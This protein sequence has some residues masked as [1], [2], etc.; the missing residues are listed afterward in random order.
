M[1]GDEWL[2]T[3]GAAIGNKSTIDLRK[4]LPV[5]ATAAEPQRS[6][7]VTAKDQQAQR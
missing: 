3:N 6:A 5:G 2:A 1:T 4:L 7:D